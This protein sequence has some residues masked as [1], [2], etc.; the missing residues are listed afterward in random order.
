MSVIGPKPYPV[1]YDPT[2][3]LQ[4]SL[5][6]QGW[7]NVPP[8]T[9]GIIQLT[10]DITA[11]P[12]VG[13]QA[14]TLATVNTN[15][16]SF[17][18]VNLTVDGKGRIT[19]ASSGTINGVMKQIVFGSL[20]PYQSTTS[21][22]YVTTTLAVTLIPKS[23]TSMLIVALSGMGQLIG[24]ATGNAFCTIKR[25]G[26]DLG[27]GGGVSLIGMESN[28]TGDFLGSMGAT[29]FVPSTSTASTTFEVFF[30]TNGNGERFLFPTIGTGI[31]SVTEF[32]N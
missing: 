19:A 4:Y 26:T 9:S 12:G 20:A 5:P 7:V 24:V 23:R 15:V 13:A 6:E 17:T 32:E 25:D 1:I 22:S 14:A 2:E 29:L 30:R 8:D 28:N 3:G 11:G 18:N 10:G 31:L 21:G 16:G 27:T